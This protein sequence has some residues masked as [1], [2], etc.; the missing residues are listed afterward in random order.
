MVSSSPYLPSYYLPTGKPVS[1]NVSLALW[2]QTCMN[3]TTISGF[4]QPFCW[5]ARQILANMEDI[6]AQT[7]PHTQLVN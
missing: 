6:R 4:W 7:S 2:M 5:Q 1:S 3:N